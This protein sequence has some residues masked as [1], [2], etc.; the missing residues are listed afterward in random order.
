MTNPFLHRLW[1]VWRHDF[2][3]LLFSQGACLQYLTFMLVITALYMLLLP[4]L[5]PLH[6][7]ARVAM[8]WVSV[9]VAGLLTT[10]LLLA[11]DVHSGRLALLRIAGLLP[12][13]I[14]SIKWSLHVLCSLIGSAVLVGLLAIVYALPGE[15]IKA[16]LW[17][18]V[19]ATPLTS[20]LCTLAA[21]LGLGLKRHANLLVAIVA[22]LMILIFLLAST[23]VL[24]YTNHICAPFSVPLLLVAMLLVM[25]PGSW[26]LTGRLIS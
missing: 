21:A 18:V 20:A 4:E 19:L 23:H 17:M 9:A 16:L 22:P 3:Y 25:L 26:W 1:C 5:L 11:D 24:C 2:R 15:E 6:A 13:E 14:A 10:P 12:M 7:S 8:L